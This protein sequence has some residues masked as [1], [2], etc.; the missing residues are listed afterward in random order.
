M[1]TS[2]DVVG[3]DLSLTGTGLA[4]IGADGIEVG[5]FGTEGRRDASLE[6]RRTRIE[7]LAGEILDWVGSPLAALVESP[8]YNSSGGHAHDRSGLWW[9]V[10]TG[11]RT[12]GVAVAELAPATLKKYVT[13][14]GT[15]T[16]DAMIA[17]TVRRFP[18]VDVNNN[19]VADALG[20]ACVASRLAGSP[21]DGELSQARQQAYAT[22]LTKTGPFLGA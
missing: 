18:D 15:S 22:F 7:T 11:L 10:V 19:N 13:G 1:N 8:S 12:R 4:R 6:E 2:S 9:L 21:V 3:I 20:L 5:L 16:K 17:A 14:K